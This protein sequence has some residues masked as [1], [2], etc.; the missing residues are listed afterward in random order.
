MR[1][2]AAGK[3]RGGG[4]IDPGGGNWG[5]EEHNLETQ[6]RGDVC[7]GRKSRWV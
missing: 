6:R 7:G 1:T 3:E 2:T 4:R 5:Y